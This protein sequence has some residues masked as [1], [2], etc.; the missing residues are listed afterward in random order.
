[1][2]KIN[3]IFWVILS[4]VF[5]AFT[6]CSSD[7]DSSENVTLLKKLQSVDL[8]Q[9]AVHKFNY[10]GTKLSKVTF[11]IEGQTNGVGY[12]KYTYT[13]DLITEVKTYSD[14]NQLLAITTLSYNSSNQLVEVVKVE[15]DNDYGL[16]TVFTYNL[17][18]TVTVQSFSGNGSVQDNPTNQ[19]TTFYFLNGEIDKKIYQSD[20]LNY[21]TEYA[22][23]DLKNPFQNVTGFNAIKLY[24]VLNNGL[25]GFNHNLLQQTTYFTPNVV[26]SQVD[27]ELDY[28]SKNFPTTRVATGEFSGVYQYTY[29]YY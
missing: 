28:N 3:S 1:M 19:I 12:D 6:S 27:F 4:I 21:T 24:S 10:K 17:V 22:Y 11:E 26:D 2:K 5:L 7:S 23:D 15:P 8:G 13:N 16:R 29:E 14:D 18:G 9:N 25:F 20:E